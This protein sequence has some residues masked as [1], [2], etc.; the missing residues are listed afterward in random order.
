MARFISAVFFA[1]LFFSLVVASPESFYNSRGAGA[2][3]WHIP[4]N[5]ESYSVDDIVLASAGKELSTQFFTSDF[6]QYCP[7]VDKILEE[8]EAALEESD[9]AYENVCDSIKT[10]LSAVSTGLDYCEQAKRSGVECPPDEGKLVEL[11]EKRLEFEKSY[12][13]IGADDLEACE[14]E[15]EK[16]KASMALYCRGE[17]SP[18]TSLCPPVSISEEWR[19][20]C[21]AN[22]GAPSVFVGVDGCEYPH[23]GFQQAAL[24]AGSNESVRS[25]YTY[26]VTANR[27]QQPA[28]PNATAGQFPP[29]QAA[30]ASQATS[31]VQPVISGCVNGTSSQT[32]S[33]TCT[34]QVCNDNCPSAPQCSTGQNVVQTGTSVINGKTCPAYSCETPTNTNCASQACPVYTQPTCEAD[35]TV[36]TYTYPWTPTNCASPQFTKQCTGYRCQRSQAA[37]TSAPCPNATQPTCSSGQVVETTTYSYFAQG[38]SGSNSVQCPQYRCVTDCAN[39]Q[40]IAH[41]TQCSAGG[42]V[43]QTTQYDYYSPGCSTSIR[44]W[45]Y[46][47]RWNATQSPR[48]ISGYAAVAGTVGLPSESSE[49]VQRPVCTA[50]G[51]VDKETFLQQCLSFRRA[52]AYGTYSQSSIEKTCALEVRRN[53]PEFQKLCSS[54]SDP[55]EECREKADKSRGKLN[56][57]YLRCGELS[58]RE[59]LLS[60]FRR[61]VEIECKRKAL[62]NDAVI[63]SLSLSTETL[64]PGDAALVELTRHKVVISKA[65]LEELKAELKRDILLDIQT[66]LAAFLGARAEQENTEATLKLENAGRLLEAADAMTGVCK[67]AE[68]PLASQCEEKAAELGTQGNA[69]KREAEAQQAGAG[70]ILQLIAS[71]FA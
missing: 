50:G 66:R 62:E 13:G 20:Q 47:C 28:A 51:G 67:L 18:T 52:Y 17:T 43:Y 25:N 36:E 22:G 59:N 56:E 58:T 4:S 14:A 15:F 61:K 41:N 54:Q 8:F 27:S 42:E 2:E 46:G 21:I 1:S 39:A 6:T 3:A 30:N 19:S 69:L 16:N 63:A 70:G 64:S 34:I 71:L 60:L 23:C 33:P 10:G 68:E 45:S 55:F 49:A 37:C 5:F 40:C 48:S 53:M 11:C 57:A 31:C 7:D 12:A 65:Q 24:P 44:C 26:P 35:Q 32:L 29:S 9:F 38:C